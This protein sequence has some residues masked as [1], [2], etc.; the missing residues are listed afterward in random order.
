MNNYSD[1]ERKVEMLR[2]RRLHNLTGREP[3][4]VPS[5][6]QVKRMGKGAF[7][8]KDLQELS[9]HPGGKGGMGLIKMISAEETGCRLATAQEELRI[10]NTA[11]NCNTTTWRAGR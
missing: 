7:A 9:R 4:M 8:R 11:L 6:A 5:K 3:S 10:K 1:L 2:Q